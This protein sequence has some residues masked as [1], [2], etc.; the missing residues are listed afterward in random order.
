M[1][2]VNI[3]EHIDIGNDSLGEFVNREG[4]VIGGR[5]LPRKVDPELYWRA[6]EIDLTA[7]LRALSKGAD[8][9]QFIASWEPNIPDYKALKA[10][11]TLFRKFEK[12]NSWP[13]LPSGEVLKPGM[14]DPRIPIHNSSP[15][16]LR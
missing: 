10:K 1:G 15:F 8:F 3:L 11:L 13:K 2:V 4:V 9:N 12:N 6:K 5:V 14:D 7:P 16:S